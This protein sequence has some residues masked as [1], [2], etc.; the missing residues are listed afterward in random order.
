MNIQMAITKSASYLGQLSLYSLHHSL[1]VILWFIILWTIATLQYT[2]LRR[3]IY[4]FSFYNYIQVIIFFFITIRNWIVTYIADNIVS[5][6]KTAE[7]VYVVLRLNPLNIYNLV[8]LLLYLAILIIRQIIVLKLLFTPKNTVWKT[9]L[10]FLL[11][12][13]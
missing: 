9:S 7:I 13:R 6:K 11:F 2:I 3:H 5:I 12:F 8:G 1:L 4:S 10:Q